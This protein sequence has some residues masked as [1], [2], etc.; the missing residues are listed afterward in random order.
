MGSGIAACCV[1]QVIVLVINH[2]DMPIEKFKI[3]MKMPRS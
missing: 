3:Q 2:F 1:P